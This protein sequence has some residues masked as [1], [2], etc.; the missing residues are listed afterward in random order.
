MESGRS[1]QEGRG[2]LQKEQAGA[3]L[4]PNIPEKSP[5]GLGPYWVQQGPGLASLE[6]RQAFQGP[7]GYLKE[8]TLLQ[9]FC[10]SS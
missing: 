9:G 8:V 4:S 2:Q 5:W 10:S 6:E 3:Q 7:E 1:W